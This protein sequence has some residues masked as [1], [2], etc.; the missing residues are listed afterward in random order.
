MFFLNVGCADPSRPPA[1]LCSIVLNAS[2]L[3]DEVNALVANRCTDNADSHAH[4]FCIA[5]YRAFMH[6]FGM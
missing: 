6:V 3:Q 1:R 4:R 5:V 2:P